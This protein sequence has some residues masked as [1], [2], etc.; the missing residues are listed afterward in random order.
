MNFITLLRH[1]IKVSVKIYLTTVLGVLLEYSCAEYYVAIMRFH[2]DL[3]QNTAPNHC[4]IHLPVLQPNLKRNFHISQ[5]CSVETLVS[6]LHIKRCKF[7]SVLQCF[8]SLG[9][10]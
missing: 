9:R 6:C 3:S 4:D 7:I 1:N 10:R 8:F 5:D 2:I